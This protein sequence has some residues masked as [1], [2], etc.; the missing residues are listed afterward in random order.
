MP[1][2]PLQSLP[3]V[4]ANEIE[5][6]GLRIGTTGRSLPCSCFCETNQHVFELIKEATDVFPSNRQRLYIGNELPLGLFM[7]DDYRFAYIW[8]GHA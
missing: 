1:A 5:S 7:N 2:T 8:F 4:S 6:P 3:A